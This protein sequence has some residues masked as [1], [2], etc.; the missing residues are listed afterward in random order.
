[1]EKSILYPRTLS[2]IEHLSLVTMVLPLSSR[3][4]ALGGLVHD[5]GY[6]YATLIKKDG[7]NIGYQS[8]KFHDELFRDICIEINGFKLLNYG[9]Y[10][11]L[12]LVGWYCWN[13]YK[14]RG[15]HV[16]SQHQK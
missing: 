6:M 13:E 1:M 14:E 8:Q 2:L 3:D 12:R 10:Y 16:A 15:T 5:Y 11:T 4:I 7:S 9:A